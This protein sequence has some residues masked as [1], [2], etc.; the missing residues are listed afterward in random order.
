LFAPLD[1]DGKQTGRAAASVPFFE[2]VDESL[3]VFWRLV[4][5]FDNDAFGRRQA[6]AEAG[7]AP[8][9]FRDFEF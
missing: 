5:L 8:R 9:F 3:F 6:D 1:A 7:A 4:A 2:Q